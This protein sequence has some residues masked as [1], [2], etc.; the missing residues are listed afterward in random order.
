MKLME[1]DLE[2][3]PSEVL[4]LPHCA[5][6]TR[7]MAAVSGFAGFCPDA[8]ETVLLTAARMGNEAAFSAL[9][10]LNA[11]RIHRVTFRIT[12]NREDAEDA[13]QECFKS[14]FAHLKSFRG[15]SRFST[16]LTSIAQR[17]ALMKVRGRRRELLSFDNS[18][19]HLIS[20]EYRHVQRPSLTPHESYSRGELASTLAEE[21]A[22]LK[23]NLQKAVHLCLMEQ[24]TCQDAAKLLGISNA[25]LKARVHRG[26]LA[27]RA[28]LNRRG[29]GPCPPANRRQMRSTRLDQGGGASRQVMAPR[30]RP[31][32]VD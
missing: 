13:L 26:R 15:Q 30:Y 21:M 17:C 10:K 25:A 27:L 28:G 4:M 11:K 3:T 29:I 20:A 9:I 1:S 5:T 14:A 2:A 6:E 8:E 31:D 24:Q 32:F 16:W 22:R 19:E 12:R 23:P 7:V 18:I